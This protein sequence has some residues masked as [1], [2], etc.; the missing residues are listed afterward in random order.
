MSRW[1]YSRD[2]RKLSI[3]EEPNENARNKK[4]SIIEFLQLAYQH[5]RYSR[6]KKYCSKLGNKKE[7]IQTEM[8]REK[9]YKKIEQSIQEL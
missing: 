5:T 6:G 7:M 3:N 8:R 4:H 9:E 2:R 1:V